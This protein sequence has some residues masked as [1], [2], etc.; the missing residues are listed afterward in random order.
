METERQAELLAQQTGLARPL[1]AILARLAED[2]ALPASAAG[3][4]A[5]VL[6]AQEAAL[7]L[8]GAAP[9]YAPTLRALL[10]QVK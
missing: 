5:R 3:R 4:A 9:A 2:R 7:R 8:P 6:L 1:C 10:A